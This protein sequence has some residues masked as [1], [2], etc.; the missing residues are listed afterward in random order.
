MF[1]F[2]YVYGFLLVI[3]YSRNY[4]FFLPNPIIAHTTPNAK[5]YRYASKIGLIFSRSFGKNSLHT[6]P[7][8]HIPSNNHNMLQKRCQKRKLLLDIFLAMYVYIDLYNL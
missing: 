3:Q 8:I 5:K 7:I 4:L 6:T 1:H 2:F